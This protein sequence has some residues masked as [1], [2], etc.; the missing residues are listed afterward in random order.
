MSR[1]PSVAE[2]VAEGADRLVELAP[3]VADLARVLLHGFLLPAVRHRPQQ[4]NQRRRTRRNHVLFDAELDELRILFE[5]GAEEHLAR[6]EHHDE[7]RARVDVRGVALG[8]ELGHVRPDLTRVLAEERLPTGFVRRLER[9]QIRV[10]R[11]F[12]VDD[13]KLAA[14]QPDD[15]VRPH[16]TVAVAVGHRELLFEVAMLD[17]ACQLDHA[18]Q[19]QFAPAAADARPLERVHELAGLGAQVLAGGVERSDALQQ[20]RADLGPP[21]LGLP[22]SRGPRR[23]AF[24]PSAPAGAR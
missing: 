9:F 8:R 5:R 10:E 16:P 14:G 13:N 2:V 23:Q 18:L 15:H 22:D 6:Q 19:L 20:L 11:R 3:E 17:H 21:P 24:S 4:R 1:A 7:V 12:R